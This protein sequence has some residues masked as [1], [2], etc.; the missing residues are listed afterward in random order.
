MKLFWSNALSP[1]GHDII[2]Q[3]VKD[4]VVRTRKQRRVCFY[5][6]S[7]HTEL[8]PATMQRTMLN[9]WQAFPMVLLKLQCPR[10]AKS[11]YPPSELLPTSTYFQPQPK[12]TV[13]DINCSHKCFDWNTMTCGNISELT[14]QKLTSGKVNLLS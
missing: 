10:T 5:L 6:Y 2:N 4:H 8:R 12:D 9:Q 14:H 13:G 7:N 11:P 1:F 3:C